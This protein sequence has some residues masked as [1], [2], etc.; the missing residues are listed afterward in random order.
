MTTHTLF[1]LFFS[2]ALALVAFAQMHWLCKLYRF[3][4]TSRLHPPSASDPLRNGR[5]LIRLAV[6][7]LP[8]PAYL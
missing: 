6:S 4:H 1:L 8:T 2:A 5:R 7:P 3:L